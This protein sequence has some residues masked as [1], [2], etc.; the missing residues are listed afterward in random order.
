M[1]YFLGQETERRSA[2]SAAGNCKPSVSALQ[3]CWG[4]GHKIWPSFTLISHQALGAKH[5]E[6]IFPSRDTAAA[7]SQEN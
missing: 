4:F 6:H 2:D 5:C 1:L 3:D 7:A